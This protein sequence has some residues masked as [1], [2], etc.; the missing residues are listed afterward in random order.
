MKFKVSTAPEVLSNFGE[1]NYIAKSGIYDVTIKFASV[2]VSKGGAESIDFNLDYNGNDQV[3]YGPY[4]TDK[5]GQTLDI[6][7]KLINSLAVIA[8]MTDG[9]SFETCEEDHNV[10]KDKK[11]QT[12]TVITNFSDLPV[13]IHLQEEYSINPKTNEIQKRMVIKGFYRQSDGADAGELVSGKDIGKRLALV[14]EKYA[15]NIT[16][17]D[18]ITPEQVEAWKAS[19][20]SGNTTSKPQPK[21]VTKPSASLFK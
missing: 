1:S 11:S 15:A 8:G 12:F 7:A 16:Y 3:I 6:G 18:D 20:K 14:T 9:D 13:K 21:T 19:K 10:G 17:K 4:V 2:S 5:A